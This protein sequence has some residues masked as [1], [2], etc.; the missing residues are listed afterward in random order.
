M[1]LRFLKFASNLAVSQE[2]L[3]TGIYGLYFDA[4]F[5]IINFTPILAKISEFQIIIALKTTHSTAS[6]ASSGFGCNNDEEDDQ[7]IELEEQ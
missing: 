6:I 2:I 3:C 1:S 7:E 4:N 5:R